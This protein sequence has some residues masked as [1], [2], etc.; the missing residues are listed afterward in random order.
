MGTCCGEMDIWEAN[1]VSAAY[2]AHPCQLAEQTSCNGTACGSTNRYASQCDPDGCDFNSF[3]MGD[4]SFYGNGLTV[5]TSKPFTVVTQFL[6]NDNT[7]TGTLS[8]IR[9][10]YVQGGTVIQNSKT[11]I[12]GMTAYDS[13]SESFCDAQKAAFG[14]TTSFQKQ[15]GLSQ[16][17]T[18][19]AHGMVLVMSLW[20]DYGASMLWLDSDYPV[21]VNTSQPGVAR[22]TC[23]TTSGLPNDVESQAPNAQVIFSNIK[24]GDIGSTFT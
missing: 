7:T 10:L 19:M 8:E 3:R 13:V 1:S 14:D 6:T 18:A 4:I 20:D 12:Y 9:R 15:G 21:N 2:T 16:M 17:G 24:F 5:D 23:A 22:G 11:N